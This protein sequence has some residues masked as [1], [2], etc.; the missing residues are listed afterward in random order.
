[1]TVHRFPAAANVT[2]LGQY[3]PDVSTME[4]L[5]GYHKHILWDPTHPHLPYHPMT[6]AGLTR[7]LGKNSFRSLKQACLHWE[8]FLKGLLMGKSLC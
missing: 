7:K 1:M 4:H 6:P 8:D 5:P 3:V 2:G